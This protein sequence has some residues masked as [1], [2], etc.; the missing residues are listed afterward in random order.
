MS[1]NLEIKGMVAKLLATED[2]IVENKNVDTACFNVQTRVLTLPFWKKATDSIYTMLVL[3]EI[4]HALFTPNEDWTEQVKIPTQYVNICE[5]AR[6]EKLCKRKYLG[7]PKSF[8]SGY[9]E[10]YEQ[11]FFELKDVNI[12]EL[13]LADRVNLHFKIGNFLKIDFTDRELSIVKLIENAETFDEV[14]NASEV[15]YEYCKTKKNNSESED[16]SDKISEAR[17]A[18]EFS[19][20]FSQSESFSQSDVSDNSGE[21]QNSNKSNNESKNAQGEKS[22]DSVDS[23]KDSN[24]SNSELNKNGSEDNNSDEELKTTKSLNEKIKSLNSQSEFNDSVYVEIP[25]LNLD[26]VI[27]SNKEVHDELDAWFSNKTSLDTDEVCS[28]KTSDC[29]FRKFKQSVQREVSYLVKEFE[30]QKAAD[31]YART[32]TSRTGVLDTCKLHTYKF[33]ED[34]FKKITVVPDGKNHGLIFILDWSGSMQYVLMDTCKQLFALIWFCK[35]VS[36]PFDVYIFTNEWLKARYD[37]N[38]GTYEGPNLKPHYDKAENLLNINEAFSLVNILT[39]AVSGKELEKQILNIWRLVYYY[40]EGGYWYSIPTRYRLSGTPL[41][42]SLVA[43]HQVIP[44]FQNKNGLQKVHC[45]ILTDGEGGNLG[46]HT[47]REKY[48]Y[49]SSV[50]EKY[51]SVSGIPIYNSFLRDRKLGTTYKIY[52]GRCGMYDYQK[53]TDCLLRNLRDAFADVSFIG[54]RVIVGRDMSKFVSMYHSADDKQ[55]RIIQNDWKKTKSFNITK[56]GYHAY[57][58]ISSSI[59]SQESDF[60]VTEDA[61]KVQIKNAFEKSLSTKKSNKK[62]LKEFISLIA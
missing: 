30:C 58:G 41:N 16:A 60:T 29:D 56:S 15:L 40:S 27:G 51:L 13:S 38:S 36:I 54:I 62:I 34:L 20:Q 37:F 19:E 55:Y 31:S 53:L 45:V 18:N 39:S 49:G 32:S 1:V 9:K 8:Y 17:N 61:T 2:I 28:F 21:N 57:F 5:D 44:H 43:L 7:S 3:H 47:M 52:D 48:S 4:S 33:N 22:N 26:T 50:K 35:K 12:S 59:L 46:Y 23:Q 24:S 25:K 14:L 6:V 10:L 42:E 11:D